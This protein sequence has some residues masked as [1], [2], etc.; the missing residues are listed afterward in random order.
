MV[1][2]IF[3]RIIF[4]VV[5]NFVYFLIISIFSVFSV[6]TKTIKN[7]KWIE[8]FIKI[9]IKKLNL[10][11]FTFFMHH[12]WLTLYLPFWATTKF[13]PITMGNRPI[14]I[15]FSPKFIKCIF[16]VFF[17]I[18]KSHSQFFV[19][20][21]N[22][23]YKCFVKFFFPKNVSLKF[24]LQLFDTKRWYKFSI[25]FTKNTYAIIAL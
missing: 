19:F 20:Y 10:A 22:F 13:S 16:F 4:S 5:D 18:S 3:L 6:N 23:Q 21:E 11:F 1:W 9:E 25:Y 2:N 14:P 17:K 12:L 24:S 8:I 7:Q 15:I